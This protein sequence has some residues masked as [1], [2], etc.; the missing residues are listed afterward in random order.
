MRPSMADRPVAERD[1]AETVAE[2]DRADAVADRDRVDAVDAERAEPARWAHTSFTSTLSLILG[3][4]ATLAALS[5]RL[6][7]LGV[8]IGVVG[9]VFAAAGLSAVARRHVTGHHVA[10]LGLAFSI[11]GVVLGILAITKALPWLDGG[12]DQAAQ[13]R[14]WLDAH[15]PWMRNW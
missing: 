12:A 4:C 9:L 7:P 5:G 15:L 14:D 10:L 2:R 1:R 3:V 8:A 11:A 6:A 13:L